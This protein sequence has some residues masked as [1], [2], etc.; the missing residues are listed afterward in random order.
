MHG[1]CGALHSIADGIAAYMCAPMLHIPYSGPTPTFILARLILCLTSRSSSSLWWWW[2]VCGEGGHMAAQMGAVEKAGQG[3][4][5]CA[6]VCKYRQL[7]SS[8][9]VHA[10]DARYVCMRMCAEREHVQ[11][12]VQW[13]TL[14]QVDD[15]ATQMHTP[16][17]YWP[18][19]I[20]P[21][22]TPL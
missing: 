18:Y 7:S 10:H 12:L 20:H 13:I 3:A 16:I 15:M 9:L 1:A 2:C 21:I 8:R 5:V 14:L 22:H 17:H 11:V 6:R 19:P 4:G